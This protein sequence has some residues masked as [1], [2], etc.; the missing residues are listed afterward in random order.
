MCVI[1]FTCLF[2][3]L[4]KR[5]TCWNKLVP[6]FVMKSVECEQKA[7]NI[8]YTPRNFA[9][10]MLG[11]SLLKKKGSSFF[12]V[13]C[14]SLCLFHYFCAKTRKVQIEL[15]FTLLYSIEREK[16]HFLSPTLN[17]NTADSFSDL[18]SIKGLTFLYQNHQITAE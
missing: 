2:F 10:I 16:K 4:K 8:F 1:G 11:K 6:Y 3:S 5:Q 14:F 7:L 17:K 15:T 13:A 18:D 12:Y 9:S